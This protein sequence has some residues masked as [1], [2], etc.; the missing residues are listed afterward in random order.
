MC[1]PG[2]RSRRAFVGDRY[3][4]KTTPLP[5]IKYDLQGGYDWYEAHSMGLGERFL[6]EVQ[7]TMERVRENPKLFA[8]LHRGIR[9]APV[10]RDSHTGCFFVKRSEESQ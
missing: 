1:L 10:Q 6:S 7:R 8:E 2:K 5:Q 4:E 3:A 9:R